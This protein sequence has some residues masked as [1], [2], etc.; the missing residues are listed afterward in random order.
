MPLRTIS[1]IDAPLVATLSNAEFSG[2][3]AIASAFYVDFDSPSVSSM[4]D[5]IREQRASVEESL[6][7]TV[8]HVV[9]HQWWGTAVGNDP[10]REPVLDE[11]LAN[12]SALLYYR[13]VHGE[14][15]AEVALEEQLRG[16]YKL[17]RTFGG[18][19]S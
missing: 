12:W 14:K 17:Y 1:L 16:V 5:I 7:W 4:P 15:K 13:E 19:W 9:A 6:E 2:F 18:G 3:A 8:A 10:S 11:A